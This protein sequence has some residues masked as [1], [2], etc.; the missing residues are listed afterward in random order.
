MLL[1]LTAIFHSAWL[2]NPVFSLIAFLARLRLLKHPEAAREHLQRQLSEYRR[3]SQYIREHPLMLLQ[4][5][6]LTLCH[7]ATLL[8]VP[9]FAYRTFGF[10]GFPP[11]DI[12]VAQLL[13]TLT[14]ES[15]PLPGGLGVAEAGFL[16]LYGPIFG[17]LLTPALLV[18]R[19]IHF[20][21]PLLAGAAVALL[22]SLP[23]KK[24]G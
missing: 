23:H 2:E 16:L 20:Y 5:L 9:Y 22:S 7:L 19:G 3:C 12:M 6:L 15:L 11:L 4:L 17:L 14:V 10:S 1:F 18:C 13:L 8:A 24:R 21:L